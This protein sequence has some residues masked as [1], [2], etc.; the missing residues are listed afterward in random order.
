MFIYEIATGKLFSQLSRAVVGIGYSGDPK[1]KDDWRSVSLQD[2]GPI[3]PGNYGILGPPVFTA[4]HGPYVLHLY[5][6]PGTNT[7]GRSGFLIHGDS[8]EAP[9][10]ASK[11]C[12]ILPRQVREFI[13]NSNDRDLR[14]VS[15]LTD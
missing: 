10:T 12:I 2:Q 15:V 4:T 14:V 9:G 8:I 5:P 7:F 11:G 3:P 6:K 13:W 1:H